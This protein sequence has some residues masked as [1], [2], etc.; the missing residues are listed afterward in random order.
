M[1]MEHK[2]AIVTL[3]AG[4]ALGAAA[5][6]GFSAYR[7]SHDSHIFEERLRCKAVADAFVKE[8]NTESVSLTLDKVDYSP[9]RNSCVAELGSVYARA[10][11]M[12]EKVQDLL[13]GE[14][15]FSA[16][17]N[18]GETQICDVDMPTVV[19]DAYDYVM[20]NAAKP[21]DNYLH[22]LEKRAS[23]LEHPPQ[24]APPSGR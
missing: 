23:D 10:P 1:T 3:L 18:Y 24:F 13:S 4:M 6:G 21:Q 8:N 22:E 7:H 19:D 20:K 5:T 16:K 9:G 12:T 11:L 2:V 14:T 15:L 17:C